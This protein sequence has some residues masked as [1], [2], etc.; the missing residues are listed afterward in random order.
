MKVGSNKV[1]VHAWYGEHGFQ[2]QIGDREVILKCDWKLGEPLMLAEMD[3]EEV[4]VQ[5]EGRVG[6]KLK[7]RHYGNQVR[8]CKLLP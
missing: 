7:I 6:Q 3:N 4:T 1:N 2:V 5:Y 8:F